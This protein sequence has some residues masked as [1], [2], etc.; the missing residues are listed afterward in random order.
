MKKE[1]ICS[2]YFLSLLRFWFG[3]GNYFAFSLFFI[4][5][6]G[7]IFPAK[8]DIQVPSKSVPLS[9]RGKFELSAWADLPVCRDG[10]LM[11]LDAFARTHVRLICGRENPRILFENGAKQFNGGKMSPTSTWTTCVHMQNSQA[12]PHLKLCIKLT[13]NGPKT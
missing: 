12:G 3:I 7:F 10:R 11:P 5:V 8:G 9:E 4:L 2:V 13:Q 1:T 6:T